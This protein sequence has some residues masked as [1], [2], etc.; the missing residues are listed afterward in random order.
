MNI[1]AAAV[2][3]KC[4]ARVEVI[5]IIVVVLHAFKPACMHA[6]HVHVNVQHSYNSGWVPK[7]KVSS[8]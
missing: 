3:M 6:G 2:G 8:Y 4:L 5:V 7:I 1:D